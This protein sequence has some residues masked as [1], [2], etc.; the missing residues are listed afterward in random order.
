MTVSP[1]EGAE[2]WAAGVNSSRRRSNLSVKLPRLQVFALKAP[3]RGPKG[4]GHWQRIAPKEIE[5]MAALNPQER[6]ETMAMVA[7]F[8]GIW[9]CVGGKVLFSKEM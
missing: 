7:K 5:Q 6:C 9:D 4:T 8:Q 1:R 3:L 2:S